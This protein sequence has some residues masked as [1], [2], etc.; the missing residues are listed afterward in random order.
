M[1][2]HNRRL[3][4]RCPRCRQPACQESL[5]AAS[6]FWR[7]AP[8]CLLSFPFSVCSCLVS[9]HGG[10]QP[11]SERQ[12]GAP[13]PLWHW[14]EEEPWLLA[15]PWSAREHTAG[16][17]AAPTGCSFGSASGLLGPL[18]CSQSVVDGLVPLRRAKEA[19]SRLNQWA[20]GATR[21]PRAAPGWSAPLSCLP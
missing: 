14:Q 6:M 4:A 5:W 20:A 21:S 16:D 13:L 15:G 2:R 10:L 18:S 3:R 11:C 17:G 8:V 12:V 9:S 7:R 19:R 1:G